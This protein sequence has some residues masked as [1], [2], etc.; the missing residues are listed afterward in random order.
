VT[1]HI[2]T[3]SFA[4]VLAV[5]PLGQTGRNFAPSHIA[6]EGLFERSGVLSGLDADASF[7]AFT[8]G[9]FSGRDLRLELTR[10]IPKGED[11]S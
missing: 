5:K 11:C 2:L 8:D 3:I 9:L 4:A 7:Q 6:T 10:P 1:E